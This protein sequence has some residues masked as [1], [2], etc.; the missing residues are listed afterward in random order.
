QLKVFNTRLYR[1]RL[2]ELQQLLVDAQARGWAY[3]G[4][5]RFGPLDPYALTLA[6][7]GTIAGIAPD[8][9][10]V[11]WAFVERLAAEPAVAR[12]IEQ[13]RLQLNLYSP[14]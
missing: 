9:H 2:A 1:E 6:R 8:E 5:E 10:P 4:G 11:L 12:A 3:L 7:W 14:R 13:E